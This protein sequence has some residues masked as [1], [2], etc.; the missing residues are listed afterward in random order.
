ME[1]KPTT[2][3]WYTHT[4]VIILSLIIFFPIGLI[5]MWKYARWSTKVKVIVTAIFLLPIIG[6][7][8]SQDRQKAQQIAA[9]PTVAVPTKV[10][11]LPNT[12][13]PAQIELKTE[14]KFDIS[15]IILTNTNENDLYRC[16][17]KLNSSGLF[18]NGYTVQ[19]R[20]LGKNETITMPYA[21]FTKDDGSRFNIFATAPQSLSISCEDA[22]NGVRGW[23]YF[24][25]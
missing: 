6:G 7:A 22:G 17:L 8:S 18:N 1:T 10:K 20:Q 19:M 21:R 11:E 5:L 9:Q 12:P 25:K 16:K 14:V 4:W 3:P 13:T 15:G 2:H 24:G 23:G